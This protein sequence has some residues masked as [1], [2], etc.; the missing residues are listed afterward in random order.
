MGDF[1]GQPFGHGGFA[2][3]GLA[4]QA[5]V[6]FLPAVE[7]LNHPLNLVLPADHPV[8]SAFPGLSSQVR[9]VS[10]EEFSLFIRLFLF[11][12][13]AARS[14]AA[15]FVLRPLLLRL[16][17]KEGNHRRAGLVFRLLLLF[18]FVIFFKFFLVV[19]FQIVQIIG[20][21]S[22]QR[23]NHLFRV[24]VLQLLGHVFNIAVRNAKALDHI[25]HWLDI[26]LFGALKAQAFVDGF[27]V[28]QPRDKDD[29]HILFAFRAKRHIH[30]HP[31]HSPCGISISVPPPHG[32]ARRR[33][34]AIYPM[35]FLGKGRFAPPFRETGYKQKRPHG[36]GPSSAGPKILPRPGG[37]R[38]A[39][40]STAAESST[41]LLRRPTPDRLHD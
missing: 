31:S 11:L 35:F 14:A 7:D 16:H 5:G 26:Q 1:G 41:D 8:Q 38:P 30:D 29:G 22:H 19:F 39:F 25:R 32:A 36:S 17:G 23:R 21:A 40:P 33:Q 13:P 34:I 18:F 9:G 10:V 28:F 15:F 6:V 24:G 4:D 12:P 20:D 2:H 3:A 27:A 37:P